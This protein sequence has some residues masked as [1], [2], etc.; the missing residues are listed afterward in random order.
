MTNA[1]VPPTPSGV[2][3][4]P[5]PP[6]TV[7]SPVIVVVLSFITLGIYF[8]YWTY[9]VFQELKDHT[10]T[11]IGGPIGLLLGLC[12]GFV[13]WFLLPSEIEKMYEM[14]GQQSPVTAMTGFWNFLPLIGAIIW[15]LKMQNALND[16]WELHGA[17]K[18]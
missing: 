18:V 16:H 8:L 15:I 7:R 4:A 3:P 11:G 12:V 5:G 9:S 6:G 2:V 13:N 1:P 10:G 17:V 14:E